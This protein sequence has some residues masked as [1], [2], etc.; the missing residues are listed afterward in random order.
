MTKQELLLDFQWP[1]G[2]RLRDAMREENRGNRRLDFWERHYPGL[3]F[4]NR[5][6]A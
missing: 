5:R 3:R 2:R 1:N 4:Q 6:A